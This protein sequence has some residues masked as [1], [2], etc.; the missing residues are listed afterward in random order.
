[1]RFS[2]QWRCC[3]WYLGCNATCFNLQHWKYRW[4]VSLKHLYLP[5]IPHCSTNEKTNSNK[6]VFEVV[7]LFTFPSLIYYP[8]RMRFKVITVVSIMLMYW[9]L[10]S[11]N[12]TDWCQHFGETYCPHLQGQNPRQHQ[13]PSHVQ[14]WRRGVNCLDTGYLPKFI[15]I[16]HSD[17]DPISIDQ[18]E[19]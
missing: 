7:P 19:G 16:L 13:C 1:M 14:G 17:V 15:N 11:Y 10:A 18:Q 3:C 9:V 6:F 2:Q 8:S 5:T 4:Y 12:F